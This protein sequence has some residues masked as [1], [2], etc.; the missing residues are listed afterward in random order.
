MQVLCKT[1]GIDMAKHPFH[2][3]AQMTGDTVLDFIDAKRKRDEAEEL[4]LEQQVIERW[5]GKDN[6]RTG[7]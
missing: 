7:K 3:C 4:R 5:T 6:E 2:S 1:C